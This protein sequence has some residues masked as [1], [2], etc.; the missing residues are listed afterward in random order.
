MFSTKA[1]ENKV[2]FPQGDTDSLQSQV[3][4][5]LR[6]PLAVAVVFSIRL[7]I[8]DMATLQSEPLSA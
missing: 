1:P 3:I 8:G 5:W 2:A 6:F 7:P 4:D